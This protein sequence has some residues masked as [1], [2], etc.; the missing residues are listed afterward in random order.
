MFLPF[1]A[2]IGHFFHSSFIRFSAVAF[3]LFSC[4]KAISF[5]MI[6]FE[7]NLFKVFPLFIYLL[8]SITF[9]SK[10][11]A[12]ASKY[13]LNFAILFEGFFIHILQI[14]I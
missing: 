10:I 2:W 12:S 5:T 7:E 8:L 14:F 9:P 3:L 1:F 4:F 11:D 13:F 6:R